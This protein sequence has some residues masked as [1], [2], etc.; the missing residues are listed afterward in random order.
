MEITKEA[1]GLAGMNPVMGISS[2]AGSFIVNV[3]NHDKDL[4]D[5]NNWKDG[6]GLTKSLDMDDNLY[7][8]DKNGK[9]FAKHKFDVMKRKDIVEA[10]ECVDDMSD[11]FYMI[12]EELNMPYEDR[13]SHP[14]NFI[15]TLATRHEMLT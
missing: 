5:D 13:P 7:G 12:N 8:I 3:T 10:Y 11:I 14:R 2:N 15:Y 1:M 6:I 9:F 4:D